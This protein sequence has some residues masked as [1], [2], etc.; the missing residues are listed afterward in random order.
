M[1]CDSKLGVLSQ[2]GLKL[3]NGTLVELDDA[4]AAKTDQVMVVSTSQT[5]VSSFVV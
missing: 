5:V 4:I 1:L 2:F 3:V